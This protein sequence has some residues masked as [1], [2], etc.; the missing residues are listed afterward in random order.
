[1]PELRVF[2]SWSGDVSHRAALV[3]SQQL[4]VFHPLI[5][6]F[7]SS[8]DVAKGTIWSQTILREL[9]NRNFGILFLTQ[10]NIG[11]QWL[12]FEAGAL[13]KQ[14]GK[15]HLAPVLLGLNSRLRNRLFSRTGL[16]CF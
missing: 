2:L 14:F 10:E 16:A 11:A 3:F 6:P 15:S 4:Q 7:V 5:K 1:M 12:H 13:A 9:E 8:E